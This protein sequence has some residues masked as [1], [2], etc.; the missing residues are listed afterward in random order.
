MNFRS[1]GLAL[2]LS[3]LAVAPLAAQDVD[4][5]RFLTTASGVSGVAAALTGLGTCD[6]EIWHGYAYDEATG[7]ENKDHLYFACQYY[8]KEDEQMYDKS[9]VA[10][11][12]FWDKKAVLESLT[13]LP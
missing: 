7:S 10:K 1:I 12:Q 8:D 6:T 11:F 9:V 5:G 4:F 2:G 13:Y 3:V